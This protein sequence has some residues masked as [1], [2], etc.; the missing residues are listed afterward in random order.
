MNEDLR[1]YA[2]RAKDFL[3]T[4]SWSGQGVSILLLAALAVLALAFSLR[5]TTETSYQALFPDRAL[6]QAELQKIEVALG[7]AEL[8][9]VRRDG[10]LHVPS[11]QRSRY[12][13]AI[14]KAG[15]LPEA[16]HDAADESIRNSSIIEL[17]PQRAERRQHAR[18]KELRLAIRELPG[19]NDVTVLFDETAPRS[20][21]AEKEITAVVNVRTPEGQP[22]DPDAVRTIHDMVRYFK[23][24]LM[25]KN[26]LITDLRAGTTYPGSMLPELGSA[27]AR[28]MLQRELERQ[29]RERLIS[30]L[31]FVPDARVAIHVRLANQSASVDQPHDVR[32]S[33]GVPTSYLHRIQVAR[34]N[35][36][37]RDSGESVP[38][39]EQIEQQTRE[40]IQLAVGF[41]LPG[42][43]T[44]AEVK[45]LVIVTSFEDLPSLTSIPPTRW[46]QRFQ[47]ASAWIFVAVIAVGVGWTAYLVQSQRVRSTTDEPQLKVVTEDVDVAEHSSQRDVETTDDDL[48]RE[49]LQILVEEDPEAAARSLANWI[50]KAS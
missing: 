40:K 10:Q 9:Y 17:G 1:Q 2:L 14:D 24:G 36:R 39:L 25:S 48:L 41:H 26:I 43:P 47:S 16:F 19:V 13:S 35:R 20:L 28:A 23:A 37:P 32:V 33:V 3:C 21:R 11:S 49:R 27:T 4:L 12:F 34:H 44:E 22:L 42:A 5:G 18:E 30:V 31:S 8:A 6:N 7:A 29:W 46:F 38:T 45:N 50:D 15:C